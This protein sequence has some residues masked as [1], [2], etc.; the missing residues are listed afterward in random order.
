MAQTMGQFEREEGIRLGRAEGIEIGRT[1][2]TEVSLRGALATV[3][4]ARFGE[5]PEAVQQS[6]ESAEVV[7]LNQWLTRA[8]TAET[9]EAV[10]IET[11]Q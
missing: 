7:R 5:L 1:Q 11:A 3:L 2:G 10:G 8:A 6:I 4:T 9:L